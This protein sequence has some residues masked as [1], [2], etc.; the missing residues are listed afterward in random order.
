MEHNG[1]A[2]GDPD[3]GVKTLREGDVNGV[4]ETLGECIMS[5][6]RDGT[7]RSGDLKGLR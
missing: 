2:T 7:V 5:S 4:R 6:E 3:C 1:A